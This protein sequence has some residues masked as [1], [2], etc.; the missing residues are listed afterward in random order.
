MQT[1]VRLAGWVEIVQGL[2]E[3]ERVVT[4]GQQRIQG[5]GALLRVA[6][7]PAG[8][9]TPQAPGASAEALPWAET[10]PG[11]GPCAVSAR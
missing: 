1:G 8:E 4:A 5:D 3:G 10:P 6:D 7:A 11:P 9:E 2:A